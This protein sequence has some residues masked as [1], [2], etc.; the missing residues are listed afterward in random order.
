MLLDYGE[1]IRRP[2]G[3]IHWAGT[4]TA[5]Y[6]NGYMEGAVRAGERAAEEVLATL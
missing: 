4:E 2:V 1:V 3:P 5:T 6:W